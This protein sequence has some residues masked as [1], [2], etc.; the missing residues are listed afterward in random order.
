MH[1]SKLFPC[2]IALITPAVAQS[3]A[4]TWAR[5]FDQKNLEGHGLDIG[6]NDIARCFTLSGN[7][8]RNVKSIR[9]FHSSTTF[10]PWVVRCELYSDDK[11]DISSK[12]ETVATTYVLND[13]NVAAV[14]CKLEV[15]HGQ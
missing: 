9:T 14:H 5:V 4:T 12:I 7:V 10:P 15:G 3:P 2:V 11:C 1:F 13:T 8:Y 6:P